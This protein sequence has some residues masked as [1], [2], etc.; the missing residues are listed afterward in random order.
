MQQ[1]FAKRKEQEREWG[2]TLVDT[3]DF[4]EYSDAAESLMV[5]MGEH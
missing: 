2:V 4:L 3:S 5:S 1:L